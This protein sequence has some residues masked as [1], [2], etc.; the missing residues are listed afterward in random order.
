MN[1]LELLGAL[2]LFGKCDAF[3][4]SDLVLEVGEFNGLLPEGE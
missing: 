3:L 1:V 4:L 2:E